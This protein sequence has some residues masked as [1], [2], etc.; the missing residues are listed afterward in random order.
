VEPTKI[1]RVSY[2][3]ALQ[4]NHIGT[5]YVNRNQILFLELVT[6]MNYKGT[7]MEP[8]MLI[9]TNYYLRVS[10]EYGLQRNHNGTLF[11]KRNLIKEFKTVIR[12]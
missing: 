6:S 7:I 8:F 2:E 9:G 11:R 5:F 4:R 3:Y 10:N 12:I 1:E